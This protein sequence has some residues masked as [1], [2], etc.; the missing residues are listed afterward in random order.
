MYETT[1][2][3][4]VVRKAPTKKV[5]AKGPLWAP[6]LGAFVL[7]LSRA[8]LS[9]VTRLSP[10]RAER[11]ERRRQFL[12]DLSPFSR[13]SCRRAATDDAFGNRLGEPVLDSDLIFRGLSAS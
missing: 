2:T 8:T 11:K 7:S 13:Y 6:V 5:A 9:R 12:A 1:F 4:N 10:E 3:T